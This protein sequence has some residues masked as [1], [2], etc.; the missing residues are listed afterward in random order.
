MRWF[1]RLKTNSVPHTLWKRK[2]IGP[3]TLMNV[4]FKWEAS[5]L[6]FVTGELTSSEVDRMLNLSEVQMEVI[7][8]IPLSP[9]HISV[10]TPVEE[11]SEEKSVEEPT[12]K[13][14]TT[15]ES[16]TKESTTK[17]SSG[18]EDSKPKSLEPRKARSVSK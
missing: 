10:V 11:K 8:D 16:T 14:S 7:Q 4:P 6:S 18:V 3:Y 2:G 15:K 9:I 1:A 12:T 17:E 13:E 5:S